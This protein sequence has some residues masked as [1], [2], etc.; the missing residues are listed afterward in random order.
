[1]SSKP[2]KGLFL[3]LGDAP[4]GAA[5]PRGAVLKS[6]NIAKKRAGKGYIDL[7]VIKNTNDDANP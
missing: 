3:C 5:R 2:R 4:E 7:H 6:C 1:M